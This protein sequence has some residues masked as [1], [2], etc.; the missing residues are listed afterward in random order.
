S[1]RARTGVADRWRKLFRNEYVDRVD[2]VDQGCGARNLRAVCFS[3]PTGAGGSWHSL[4][5][6]AGA[7][8][9]NREPVRSTG[10]CKGREAMPMQGHNLSEDH[11]GGQSA[12]T[13]EEG[14]RLDL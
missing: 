4:L 11:C 12:T 8:S 14:H 5:E 6:L 7:P 13:A 9:S 1:A 3:V 10:R 2:Q